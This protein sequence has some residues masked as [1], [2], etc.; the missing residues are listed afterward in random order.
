MSTYDSAI[1]ELRQMLFDGTSNKSAHKKTL[2][3]DIDG[4]NKSFITYDKRIIKASFKC[5]VDDTLTT[6]TVDNEVTGEVTLSQPPAKNTKVVASYFW[7]FWLDPELKNFLNKGAESCSAFDADTPD[8]ASLQIPPGLKKA[9]LYFAAESALS[10]QINYL[11]NRRHSEEFNIEQDG[12]DESA[13]SETISAMRKNADSYWEKA[14]FHR[15]DFYKKAG[16]RN[17]PAFG[18]KAGQVKR[19]GPTR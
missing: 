1:T 18:F 15:D 7:R 14:V 17:K 6:A 4:S 9:A 12:N 2:I 19:Y 10:A 16:R 8:E 11:V 13:F 5:Y 3:G